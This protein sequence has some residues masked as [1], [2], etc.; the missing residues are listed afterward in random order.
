MSKKII[1]IR[2]DEEH[3]HLIW[4]SKHPDSRSENYGAFMFGGR[5]IT[6]DD[7]SDNDY[8]EQ[9]AYALRKQQVKA[10]KELLASIFVEHE[11]MEAQQ[12]KALVD[13][14]MNQWVDDIKSVKN[15]FEAFGYNSIA[16]ATIEAIEK[17]TFPNDFEYVL[18]A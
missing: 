2:R 4:A 13:N 11:G 10:T 5:Q 16:A 18:V 15:F 12:A 9:A 17:L 7:L 1:E 3:N 8:K 14:D 6:A